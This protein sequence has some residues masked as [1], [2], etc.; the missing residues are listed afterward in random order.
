MA[1]SLSCA[2]SGAK[3]PGKF[4]TETEKELMDHVKLHMS[5]S[6]PE[7]VKSPPSPETLKKMIKQV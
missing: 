3:C 4:V 6:H 2:D 5:A 7:M 1:Y